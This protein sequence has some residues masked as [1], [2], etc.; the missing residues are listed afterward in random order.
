VLK[1][2]VFFVRQS[3]T[4]LVYSITAAGKTKD[5]DDKSDGNNGS[6]GAGE[7]FWAPMLNLGDNSGLLITTRA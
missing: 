2:L 1:I 5:S 6:G 3:S 4:K 7:L